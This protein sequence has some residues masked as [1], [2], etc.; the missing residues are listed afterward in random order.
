MPLNANDANILC[1]A[2]V[3]ELLKWKPLNAAIQN[4]G[5]ESAGAAPIG[6]AIENFFSN[7]YPKKIC[8]REY[9]I[10]SPKGRL[11][12]DYALVDQASVGKSCL[13]VEDVIEVKFNYA[14]QSTELKKRTVKGLG[15]AADYKN[16]TGAADAYL[17][18]LVADPFSATKTS[19]PWDSGWNYWRKPG[20]SL[21]PS[22]ITTI[23]QAS[24]AILGSHQ[25]GVP[26]CDLYC[27][28]IQI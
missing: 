5:L 4:G 10:P 12:I 21:I 20:P 2:V 22:A 9:K 16:R 7:K 24:G 23:T 8:V 25:M 18:Y 17:L 27:A 19:K 28:L 3:N 15:Q 6:I 14:S 13:K 26:W 1:A 11:R